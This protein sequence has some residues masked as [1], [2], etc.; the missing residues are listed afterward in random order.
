MNRQG[1][2]ARALAAAISALGDAEFPKVFSSFTGKLASF[3]NLIFIYYCGE[4]NPVV[5]FREYVDPIV[6][7]PMDSEYVSGAYL[8]D[9]FYHEHLKG[10]TRGL[11]RLIDVAPDQ[12]RRSRYFKVYYRQTTLIDEL[13]IFGQL[14]SN[15]TITACFGR[16]RSSSVIFSKKEIK[17]LKEYEM[18]LS[19]LIEVNWRNFRLPQEAGAHHLPLQNRLGSE[20]EKECGIRLT[21][22]QAEVTMYILRGH[23][24][25]SIGLNLGISP[26]TVKVF[27]RQIYSKCGVSSQAE[28]FA[29]IMPLFSRL[30]A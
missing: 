10:T 28:L 5:L 22:R 19:T 11:R 12:F 21:P 27:R 20:L 4:H 18:V 17:A 6:Y 14:G 24:S 15:R 23:S 8:L 1:E 7:S 29:M 9:P 26:D 3:D 16:D 25:V 2:R 13:A 30:S